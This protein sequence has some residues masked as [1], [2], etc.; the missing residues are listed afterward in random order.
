MRGKLHSAVRHVPDVVGVV[1]DGAVGGEDARAGDVHKGHPAPLL[2]IQIGPARQLLGG[3]TITIGSITIDAK[4]VREFN[5]I[6]AIAKNE[7]ASIQQG[8]SR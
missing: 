6:V 7:T 1:P 5:D 8:V 4:N 3:D 2:L